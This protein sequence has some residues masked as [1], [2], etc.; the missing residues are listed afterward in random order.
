M[1]GP[2]CGKFF[3]VGLPSLGNPIFALRIGQGFKMR[4]RAVWI[5]SG[6]RADKPGG[7]NL[8]QVFLGQ[9]GKRFPSLWRVALPLLA[10]V[11]LIT[12]RFKFRYFVQVFRIK[13]CRPRFEL[14]K[15]NRLMKAQAHV[16][17]SSKI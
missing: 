4:M 10:K 11:Q 2:E 3:S 1:G 14:F 13:R 7:V 8:P 5:F 16:K 6:E 17:K 15:E 9:I 12:D